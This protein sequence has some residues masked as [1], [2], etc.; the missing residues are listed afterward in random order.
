MSHRLWT[1]SPASLIL[2]PLHQFL[3]TSMLNAR[4]ESPEFA[5]ED[6]RPTSNWKTESLAARQGITSKGRQREKEIRSSSLNLPADVL[7]I[8]GFRW[9][10]DTTTSDSCRRQPPTTPPHDRTDCRIYRSMPMSSVTWLQRLSDVY[11]WTIPVRCQT[12]DPQSMTTTKVHV[13]AV[14]KAKTRVSL[15][16]LLYNYHYTHAAFLVVNCNISS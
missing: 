3:R 8:D 2:P 15:T 1:V 14:D 10:R 5:S 11:G 4:Y 7:V 6:R 13:V 9:S 16:C 12:A